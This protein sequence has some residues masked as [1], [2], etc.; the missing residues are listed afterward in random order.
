MIAII[1]VVL[2]LAVLYG[3]NRFIASA[4]RKGK[5]QVPKSI[6]DKFSKL[7]VSTNDIAIISR[8][9]YE[10]P[11]EDPDDAPLPLYVAPGELETSLKSVSVLTY[12]DFSLTGKKQSFRSLPIEK[13]SA[14]LKEIFGKE[15]TITIYYDPANLSNHY[16]DIYNIIKDEL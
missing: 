8:E 7:V 11:I 9:D 16:F 4:K 12:D 15:K 13:S 1:S 3:I 10:V 6:K 14:E 2:F 5:Y